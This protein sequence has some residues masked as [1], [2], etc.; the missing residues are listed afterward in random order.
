MAS[1]D[2][3]ARAWASLRIV[4][5]ETSKLLDAQLRAEADCSLSDV[6]VLTEISCTPDRR[7]QMLTLADR[8]GVTRGGLTR[9]IDRLV[10]RGW[11]SRDRPEHNRREVYAVITDDGIRVLNQAKSTYLGLLTRTL[12]SHLDDSSFDEMGTSMGKLQAGLTGSTGRW[13]M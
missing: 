7:M 13:W 3:V 12:G 6:D 11:V 1:E 8:L 5:R 10:E 2:S 4:H 9:I